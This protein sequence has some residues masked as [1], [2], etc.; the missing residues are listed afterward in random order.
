MNGNKLLFAFI[1][2][3]FSIVV[4]LMLVYAAV[5]LAGISYDFGYR[6]FT[7]GAIDP[8]PGREITITITPDMSSSDLAKLLEERGLVRDAKLF[9]IQL[10]LSAYA[11]AVLPGT[12]QLTT[13]MDPK[14][15]IIAICPAPAVATEGTE[16]ASETQAEKIEDTEN[17][18][19]TETGIE[20]EIVDIGD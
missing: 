12:Y 5:N 11:K 18:G 6:V 8:E 3:A 19:G 2:F 17:T 10:K 20:E 7:E 13:A 16:E 14:E 15:I 9:L 4:I 1:R